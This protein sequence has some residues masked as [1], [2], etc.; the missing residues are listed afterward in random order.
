MKCVYR[1]ISWDLLVDF[2]FFSK[3]NFSFYFS[4][5]KKSTQTNRSRAQAETATEMLDEELQT[6]GTSANSLLST[7]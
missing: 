2:F 5:K 7:G 6:S 1:Q 3:Y 4:I